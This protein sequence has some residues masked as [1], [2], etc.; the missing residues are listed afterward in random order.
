MLPFLQVYSINGI[1]EKINMSLLFTKRMMVV[2]SHLLGLDNQQMNKLKFQII[3]YLII[4]E[5]TIEPP[6][7][8]MKLH[9]LLL[10]MK[11]LISITDYI[12][13]VFLDGDLIFVIK[14]ELRLLK[15]E[16]I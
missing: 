12:R 2:I 15:T 3:L 14:M 4:T 13:Q 8:G 10:T 1:M 7:I 11:E 16:V 9:T 6:K 5:Y